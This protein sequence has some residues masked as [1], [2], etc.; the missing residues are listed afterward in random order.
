M[1]LVTWSSAL[2]KEVKKFKLEASTGRAKDES[3]SS[4]L[5]VREKQ[6]LQTLEDS[7]V[8]DTAQKMWW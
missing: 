5:S 8:K 7:K 6:I 3:S 1:E 4:A 2:R